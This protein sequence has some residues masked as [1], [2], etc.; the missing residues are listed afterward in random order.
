[1]ENMRRMLPAPSLRM[2]EGGMFDSLKRAVG[3]GPPE[4]IQ[5][6][7]AREDAALK[8]KMAASAPPAPAPAPPPKAVSGYVGNSALEGRMKA[9]GLRNGG[10]L[11][12]GMGGHVPGKGSGDKIPAKYEPGEFVV[13]NDML[14]AEPELRQ[15]LRGLRE[16]VLAE[17]GM[18][19]AEADAKALNG[20]RAVMAYEGPNANPINT[21]RV[22][23]ITPEAAATNRLRI[24]SERAKDTRIA[25][26]ARAAGGQAAK[27]NRITTSP[28]AAA[29]SGN[30]I[31]F[32]LPPEPLQATTSHGAAPAPAPAKVTPPSPSVG[33]RQAGDTRPLHER[34]ASMKKG[35]E[36]LSASEAAAQVSPPA[37]PVIPPAKPVIPPGYTPPPINKATGVYKANEKLI[38]RGAAAGQAGPKTPP[39]GVGAPTAG[40]QA[41]GAGASSAGRTGVFSAVRE[42]LSHQPGPISKSTY[43]AGKVLSNPLLGFASK[44]AGAAGVLQNFN[45]YKL[46]DPDVDSSAGGTWNAL[47]GDIAAGD[48]TYP[49]TRKSL[50]KGAIEAGMDLGSFV[51]N[52]AD[53]FV[54]GTGPSQTYNRILRDHFGDQL[55]DNSGPSPESVAPTPGSDTS[56]STTQTRLTP[57]QT[58]ATAQRIGLRLND[59]QRLPMQQDP[60]LLNADTSRPE[61]G[62]SRDFSNELNGARGPLPADLRE[63]VVHKTVD[64]QG[65]VTYSGRNVG[66]RADGSTQMVDGMGRDLQMKGSLEVAAPGSFNVTPDGK[67]YAFTPV[68]SDPKERA[69]QLEAGKA[70]LRNPDGSRWSSQDNAIMAANLRDGVDP[71]RGTSRGQQGGGEAASVPAMSP[72]RA[73]LEELSRQPGKMYINQAKMLTQLRNDDMGHAASMAQIGEQAKTLRRGQDMDSARSQME[74]ESRE[75]VARAPAE[76]AAQQRQMRAQVFK[77]AGGDPRKAAQIMMQNGM[78]P[79]DALKIVDTLQTQSKAS[80]EAATKDLEAGAVT[81][82]KDGIGVID[83]GKLAVGRNVAQNMAPGFFDMDA[84]QRAAAL[85]DVQAGMNIVNGANSLRENSWAKRSGLDKTTERT[86]LPDLTGASV[87][88]V[89]FWDGAW[90]PNVGRGDV[91]I[92][93]RDGQVLYVPKEEVGEN[94]KALL[95]K[96]GAKKEN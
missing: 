79:E 31:E 63:G 70:S 78:D 14:D 45:D 21:Q 10:D 29:P 91:R 69:A 16:E 9:A 26:E 55:I 15:H 32:K 52:T 59:Q 35:K 48:I 53:L 90:R 80:D 72:L 88:D 85:P 28:G 39:V 75:R 67:G 47:K 37:K 66:Q 86:T 76:L 57:N 62:R 18:T 77:M 3:M 13:S 6:K 23:T 71:Y 58:A 36:L 56:P 34:F 83:Q 17:K 93:T 44:A 92:T 40:A 42:G 19:V 30:S 38:Q 12:T 51:A 11:R 8:A 1:M 41:G 22:N 82:N 50:G 25:Q 64:A 46:N 81:K 33:L 2:S 60:R 43:L 68:S 84:Q 73:R 95:K 27:L 94:E 4:T 20:L 24:A 96:Y 49:G 61:L 89:G 87:G 5:Q 54:P 65:R 7:F 74:T